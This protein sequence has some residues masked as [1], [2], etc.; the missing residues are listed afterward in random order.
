MKRKY[1]TPAVFLIAT[2]AIYLQDKATLKSNAGK[3]E[4]S[5]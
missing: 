3:K 5:I 4:I 1:L 2:A